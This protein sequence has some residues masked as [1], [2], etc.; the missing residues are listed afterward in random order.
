M[1]EPTFKQELPLSFLSWD[2]PVHEL[3]LIKRILRTIKILS[4]FGDHLN[5]PSGSYSSHTGKFDV[6]L[7]MLLPV[8]WIV[9]LHS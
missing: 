3:K 9:K 6:K 2:S 4:K 5:Y 7:S 1:Y 8:T